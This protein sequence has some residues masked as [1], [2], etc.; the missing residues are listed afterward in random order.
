MASKP[1]L[2]SL[3]P[4]LT[5]QLRKF[6]SVKE[7]LRGQIIAPCFFPSTKAYLVL[8]LTNFQ[9]PHLQTKESVWL[10]QCLVI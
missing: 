2:S 6:S 1:W 4:W 9:S 7:Y 5:L 10:H 3:V 8:G